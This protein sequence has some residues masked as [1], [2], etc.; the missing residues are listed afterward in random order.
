MCVAS[1]FDNLKAPFTQSDAKS[2]PKSS[3]GDEESAP[4]QLEKS[5]V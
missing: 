5:P 2:Q 1:N 4:P 3:D